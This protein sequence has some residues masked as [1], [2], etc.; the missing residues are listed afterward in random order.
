MSYRDLK[1]A[2]LDKVITYNPETGEFHRLGW[3]GRRG[4]F[5]SF[6]PPRLSASKTVLGYIQLNVL[7]QH[8]LGHRLAWFMTYGEWPE[9]IDH[10][11]GDPADNRI[12]NL[13]NCSQGENVQNIRQPYSR[14]TSGLLGVS[15]DK[16]HGKFAAGISVN[17]KR[18]ALGRFD[19][20]EEAHQRYVEAKRELHPFGTM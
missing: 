12:S 4:G 10:I 7:G 14:N 13:R 11:N 2:D 16:A 17:G 3:F 5:V 15:F 6:D 1:R 9:V 19:T 20:A 8:V 18:R